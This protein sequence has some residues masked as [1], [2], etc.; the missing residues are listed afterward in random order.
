MA[1]NIDVKQNDVI[2]IKNA[3]INNFGGTKNLTSSFETRIFTKQDQLSK[4]PIISQLKEWRNKEYNDD[5]LQSF[6]SEGPSRKSL[7]YTI[8]EINNILPTIREKGNFDLIA[9][10]GHIKTEGNSL[11]YPGCK[12]KDKCARKA[13]S[14]GEGKSIF[15]FFETNILF[16]QLRMHIL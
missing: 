7:L 6:V 8:E 12:N 16:R 3:R 13:I 1:K 2:I 14:I 15:F 11:Y 9:S 4:Y 5:H 10:I